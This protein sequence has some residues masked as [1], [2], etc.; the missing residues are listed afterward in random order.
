MTQPVD[1]SEIIHPNTVVTIQ[2][3]HPSEPV[4]QWRVPTLTDTEL[5]NLAVL[6]REIVEHYRP[7]AE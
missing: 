7:K 4:W 5:R 3:D 1:N 2:S 6:I